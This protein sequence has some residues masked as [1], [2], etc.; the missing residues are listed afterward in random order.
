MLLYSNKKEKLVQQAQNHIFKTKPAK[1]LRYKSAWRGIKKNRFIDLKNER[2][3][4]LLT[5]TKVTSATGKFS[6][7]SYEN[8]IH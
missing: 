5:K 6:N 8:N 7:S 1:L 2:G 3:G 4:F